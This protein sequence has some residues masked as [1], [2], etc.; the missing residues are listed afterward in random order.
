M[1]DDKSSRDTQNQSTGERQYELAYF[2]GKH[3]LPI[4]DARRVLQAAGRIRGDADMRAELLKQKR[5]TR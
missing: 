1:A 2:A 5:P 3:N 4:D